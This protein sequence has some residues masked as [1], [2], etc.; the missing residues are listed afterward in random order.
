MLN[1]LIYFVIY[2]FSRLPMPFL[3]FLAR[4]LAF[5][6]FYL[7]KHRKKLVI[8]NLSNS[9]PDSSEKD[10]KRVA[11]QFF[12][13]FFFS[14]METLKLFSVDI[15]ELKKRTHLINPEVFEESDFKNK[16]TIGV[17][18]HLF[19]WEWLVGIRHLLPYEDLYA[20]YHPIRNEYWNHK[21]KESRKIVGTK[22]IT[23]FETKDLV[24]NQANDGKSF[25][26]FLSDQ[27][28]AIYKKTKSLRKLLKSKHCSVNWLGRI[29]A[30]KRL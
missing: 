23:S 17:C 24:M 21:L 18:G 22:L 15:S 10:I 13:V 29:G 27:S 25:Y 8:K 11:R 9:F 14:L 3:L 20:V 5:L 16:C 26:L 19:N 4:I 2:H 12:R 6:N 28:P 7:F 1:K 30:R